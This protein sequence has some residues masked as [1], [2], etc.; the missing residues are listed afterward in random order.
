MLPGSARGRSFAERVE[1]LVAERPD[2]API[3]CPMLAAWSKLREQI[4][5]FDKTVREDVKGRPD[6]RLLM[7][8]PGIGPV[9]AGLYYVSALK[10]VSRKWWKFEGG[11]IS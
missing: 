8:V 5:A 11:V 4:A 3:V 9:S 7:S 2:V 1:A 6:C 10:V